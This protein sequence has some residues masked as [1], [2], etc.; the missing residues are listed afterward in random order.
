MG[1]VG[2]HGDNNNSNQGNLNSTEITSETQHNSK[3]DCNDRPLKEEMVGSN[4]PSTPWEAQEGWV[5][6]GHGE[7]LQR[8]ED[9]A[10]QG[11]SLMQEQQWVKQ[12]LLKHDKDIG[13]YQQVWHGGYPNRWG[14]Q[15]P[16]ESRWNLQTMET[17]M[18]DYED[19]EVVEWLRYG[20]PIGRLPTLP[21]P[22][23]ST[24]NH[25]GAVDYPEQLQKYINKEMSCGA[26]MGPYHKIPFDGKVGISPL[27]T[28]PKKGS[29]DRRVILDLSFPIGNSVNDGIPKD[30]YLGLISKLT[31]PKVDDFACRIFELGQGCLMFK[32][33]LSRYFR[34]ISMDPGDYAMIGYVINGDIYFDKVLPMGMR[35]APYIAQRITNAI[36]HIHRS[37]QY[38]LLNYVDDFVGAELSSIAWQAF[39]A[40][41]QLLTELGVE[42]A[43]DKTIPPT[44]KLEFLGITFNSESMTMGVPTDKLQEIQEEINTWLL[45]TSARRK[46]VESLIGKLQ[47]IAKC[48]KAGRIFLGRL[49]QWLRQ[50]DRKNNYR[51]PLEARK[52][53]AWW[54]RC[55]TI[56][57]G[58][59]LLWLMKEPGTDTVLQTDACPK[60]FGGI[61]GKEYFRGRFPEQEQNRNI[62]ILEIWAVMAGLKLWTHQLKGKY[63]WVHVDNEAV[64]SVLNTG[65]SRDMELQNTLGEIALI[66]AT[67]QF[68]IK[69]KHIPGVTNS[70]QDWLSRWHEP[71]ARREFRNFTKDSSLKQIRISNSILKYKHSW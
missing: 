32:I 60:G 28:R 19:K 23:H 53:I 49:I 56:Y 31:F 11:S 4:Y 47:F 24:K 61:Y 7:W 42:K 65:R 66:A 54:G 22:G 63:F 30:T 68:V 17:L 10:G 16:V 33:D 43:K 40:L 50:M 62:A 57:N 37:L 38:F 58:T 52:D 55:M 25:K 41:D 1:H 39:R 29:M 12:W 15:V 13:M 5:Y 26:V 44:T 48:V 9:L 18:R 34:Q 71:G 35:S 64:A 46:E 51:I 67:N 14:A 36:A 27:S 8:E 21:Q 45:K 3:Q 70:I 69:A 59:S 20:W 6:I 2:D